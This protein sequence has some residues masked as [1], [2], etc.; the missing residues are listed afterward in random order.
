VWAV[1][2]DGGEPVRVA[3]G[4]WPAVSGDG[5]RF[6][7]SASVSVTVQTRDGVGW[8]HAADRSGADR[9]LASDPALSLDGKTLAFTAWDPDDDEARI[10]VVDS[11]DE[12]GDPQGIGWA[13]PTFRRDGDLV[14]VQQPT[15]IDAESATGP[16]AA[17][18]VDPETGKVVSSFQYP[19]PVS[20]QDY[21]ASGTWLLVTLVDGQVIWYGGGT[22]A[23]IAT[24]YIAASW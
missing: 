24:G 13:H 17:R 12:S 16:R 15:G 8:V 9:E 20:D 21:D 10:V 22:S 6:A 5:Q 14:V 11:D 3:E 7:S 2:F 4:G 19:A 18:V 1:P 23:A